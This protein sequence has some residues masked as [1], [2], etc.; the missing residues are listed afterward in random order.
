M[1][2]RLIKESHT[3]IFDYF[4]GNRETHLAMSRWRGRRQQRAEH[5]HVATKSILYAI[6]VVQTHRNRENRIEKKKLKFK[7]WNVGDSYG[8]IKG[9]K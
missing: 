6:H 9:K 1:W 3:R 5:K 8:E 4:D 7:K 2:Q